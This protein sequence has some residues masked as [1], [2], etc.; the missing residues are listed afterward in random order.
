MKVPAQDEPLGYLLYLPGDY[1]AGSREWPLMIFLHGSGERG[2]DLELVKKNGLPRRLEDGMQL[3]GIVVS[4]QCPLDTRWS[5][6]VLEQ[7]LDSLLKDYRIDTDR[8]YLTGL[9]MGGQGTWNWAMAD[10]ERFAAIAP[11]CGKTDTTHAAALKEM[12]IWVFHGAKDDVVPIEDS[13]R[14]VEALKRMGN[15]VKFSAYPDANHDSWTETYENP[16]L[17]KWLLKHH[18]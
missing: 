3:P 11:V 16:R 9:S 13:E 5:V 6:P 7:F 14:M 8:I 1:N 17:Y 12:P 4:P 10:P 15:K 2:T 18:K